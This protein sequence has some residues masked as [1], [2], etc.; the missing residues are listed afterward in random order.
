MTMK[1][2]WISVT[3][4]LPEHGRNVLATY[5]NDCGMNRIIV[6]YHFEQW[7]EES[8][9]DGYECTDEY[10]EDLDGYYYQEG[11]Y[12]Q[13]DNW[14][15]YASIYVHEGKVTHWMPL[16]KPPEGGTS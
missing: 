6:G 7:K 12:E 4:Q 14:N 16:P 9:P 3:D 13:Q 5:R 10:S 15:D 2:E 11:W 1:Q 8:D